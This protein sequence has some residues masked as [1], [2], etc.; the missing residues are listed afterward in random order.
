MSEQKKMDSRIKAATDFGPLLIFFVT[1]V[2][3]RR[4][5][6]LG[7]DA[8]LY[9]TG[10][11]IAATLVALAVTYALERKIAPMP[12]VSGIL[13]TVF[14][15][16][17]LLLHDP[18]YLILKTTIFYGLAATALA[19]GLMMDRPFIKYIFN[20]AFALPHNAWRLLTW[21]WMF[22]FLALG[23]LNVV[24]YMYWGLDVW[25]NFKVWGVM[26]AVFLFTMSQVPFIAKNQIASETS[27]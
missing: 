15:G 18:V 22:F 21:R 14:G 6:N 23:A 5:A 8:I 24:V 19:V 20:G 7:D 25:V 11:I 16:V 26:G 12:L 3:G 27:E 9:A 13:I 17:T 10:A 2:G 1:Y 4:W